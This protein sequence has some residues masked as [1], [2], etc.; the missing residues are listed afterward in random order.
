MLELD[1]RW[2]WDSWLCQD[3]D[4]LFHVFFLNAPKSLGDPE[5]RHRNASVGHAVSTDLRTW[6]HCPDALAPQAVP[7]FDDLAVW[8]GSVVRSPAGVWTMFTTGLSA[9]D[10][11]TVQR[12]GVQTSADL[13]SWRR[14]PT[15]LL[16]ADPRWYATVGSGRPE[17]HWRDPW[18]LHAGGSWHLLA[19]ARSVDTDTA[20]VAHAVSADLTSWE[21]LPPLTTA[22][23]RFAWAEVVSVVPVDGRWVMVFCC[24]G[25]QMPT[26]PAGSGGIWSLPV[27]ESALA[28]PA[29]APPALDLDDAVRLTTE[30]LYAG[31]VVQAPG[32][33]A[34]LLA[35]RYHDA[36]GR[37]IGGLIDPVPLAWLPD[38]SGLVLVEAPAPWRPAGTSTETGTETSRAL[39]GTTSREG[40]SA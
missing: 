20:V 12:I 40:S 36:S 31:R 16:E 18:V 23:R 39:T 10:N 24:L 27:P 29:G 33:E 11:G 35:F 38:G 25:D 21:V 32:G 8:T 19:T 7:A 37:L 6:E 2:V 3:D 1:D 4:A 13:A 34:V 15:A 26:D 30:D 5:L 17:T 28:R 14:S 22:S 9:A